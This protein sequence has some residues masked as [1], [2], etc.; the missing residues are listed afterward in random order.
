MIKLFFGTLIMY[1][2]ICAFVDVHFAVEREVRRMEMAREFFR[3]V[4]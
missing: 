3:A 1:A 4:E 2:A